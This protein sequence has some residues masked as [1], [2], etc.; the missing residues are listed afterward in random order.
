MQAFLASPETPAWGATQPRGGGGSATSPKRKKQEDADPQMEEEEEAEEEAKQEVA[1]VAEPEEGDA[2]STFLTQSETVGELESAEE[3]QAAGGAGAKAAGEGQTQRKGGGRVKPLADED[4][5]LYENGY[6]PRLRY[7]HNFHHAPET[8]KAQEIREKVALMPPIKPRHEWRGHNDGVLSVHT[9]ATDEDGPGLMTAGYDY[10]IRIWNTKGK[11]LG[12]IFTSEI[13]GLPKSMALPPCMHFMLPDDPNGRNLAAEEKAKRKERKAKLEKG[14]RVEVLNARDKLAK[15]KMVEKQ[16]K[17]AKRKKRLEQ[18]AIKVEWMVPVSSST[19]QVEVHRDECD[20]L[21]K[22]ITPMLKANEDRRRRQKAMTRDRR[23]QNRKAR[24]GAGQVVTGGTVRAMQRR[25]TFG[26]T[27][28]DAHLT[29]NELEGRQRQQHAFDEVVKRAQR[30]RKDVAAR[31]SNATRRTSAVSLS[32]SLPD[33]V[34]A[35]ED[36][37]PREEKEESKSMGTKSMDKFQQVTGAADRSLG[38]DGKVL[39]SNMH[40][41]QR[42]RMGFKLQKLESLD[43]VIDTSPSDFLKSKMPPRMLAPIKVQAAIT[44]AE[45]RERPQYQPFACG[46]VSASSAPAGRLTV[47]E[48]SDAPKRRVGK[49]KGHGKARLTDANGLERLGSIEGRHT[50][51]SMPRKKGRIRRLQASQSLSVLQQQAQAQSILESDRKSRELARKRSAASQ[52]G[53]PTRAPG[54][55]SPLGGGA[56]SP[57]A[58]AANPPSSPSGEGSERAEGEG[59]ALAPGLSPNGPDIDGYDGDGREGRMWDPLAFPSSTVPPPGQQVCITGAGFDADL[60]LAAAT[61]PGAVVNAGAMAFGLSYGL[62]DSQGSG[63]VEDEAGNSLARLYGQGSVTSAL[64]NMVLDQAQ[65]ARVPPT[66]VMGTSDASQTAGSAHQRGAGKVKR[67]RYFPDG[68]LHQASEYDLELANLGHPIDGGDSMVNFAI[69]ASGAEAEAA[70]D[71]DGEED[72]KVRAA[73]MTDGDEALAEAQDIESATPDLHVDDAAHFLR[74]A[75]KFFSQHDDLKHGGMGHHGDPVRSSMLSSMRRTVEK[76]EASIHEEDDGVK[77]YKRKKKDIF[78]SSIN[79][80]DDD[81]ELGKRKKELPPPSCMEYLD[82]Q[83]LKSQGRIDD[84]TEYHSFLHAQRKA[85]EEQR[86]KAETEEKTM[87]RDRKRNDR[88]RNDQAMKDKARGNRE[89]RAKL[90]KEQS[91]GDGTE[92]HKADTQFTPYSTPSEVLKVGEMFCKYDESGEGAIDKQ[93]FLAMIENLGSQADGRM[94]LAMDKD[95]SGEISLAELFELLHRG[96]PR[97]MI[98]NM[99]EYCAETMAAAERRRL[100]SLRNKSLTIHQVQELTEL[101]RAMDSNKSGTLGI[102]ELVDVMAADITYVEPGELKTMLDENDV[103]GDGLL[104]LDEFISLMTGGKHRPTHVHKEDPMDAIDP[105]RP[106]PAF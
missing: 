22:K 51:S 6:N 12:Q 56:G 36:E 87:A 11:L 85:A 55:N 81:D 95:G 2:G 29:N 59:A 58:Q 7:Q 67:L 19:A 24:G 94:F 10:A 104:D 84:Q 69:G 88:M 76:F 83:L 89:A 70:A 57:T 27:V 102:D 17:E 50:F 103:N 66:M 91:E 38:P 30:R 93:E 3:E 64:G 98:V 105:V 35:P 62:E 1:A 100:A 33:V 101:F 5:P 49:G 39:W 46:P 80:D 43:A 72:Q 86:V 25:D 8:A 73:G 47:S 45:R 90:K 26:N 40:Q 52:L 13:N 15:Q 74:S 9:V 75:T 16:K 31:G 48:D 60:A 54:R 65:L 78:A 41:V 37:G 79:R 18:E 96:A 68:S 23:R 20:R 28:S 92:G 4:C 14:Q 42:K 61:N 97:Q 34:D 21:V 53:S 82:F 44:Q 99:V 63:G 71:L 106:E 32:A 77:V